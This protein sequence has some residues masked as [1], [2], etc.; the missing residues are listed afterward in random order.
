MVED[1]FAAAV[2]D[3]IAAIPSFRSLFKERLTAAVVDTML[4]QLPALDGGG[5]I[6]DSYFNIG[7]PEE[8]PK[9][10]KV[11]FVVDP[12]E[13]R[14]LGSEHW[15]HVDMDSVDMACSAPP[16][17]LT[18]TTSYDSYDNLPS[19]QVDEVDEED[20]RTDIPPGPWMSGFNPH[21]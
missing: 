14:Y 18:T 17:T 8:E 21:D 3:Q 10:I 12:S 6:P 13:H 7:T 15:E 9:L 1:Q 11:Q 4:V 16:V 20:L 19:D 2:E 5:R